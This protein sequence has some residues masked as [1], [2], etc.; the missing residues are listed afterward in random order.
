GTYLHAGHEFLAT[1][2]RRYPPGLDGCQVVPLAALL[3]P[4]P[5]TGL[6]VD[7]L[8]DHY[9]GGDLFALLDAYLTLLFDV[10]TTLFAYGVALE[11]H[12]QNTSLVLDTEHGRP[13]VRLLL[14]DH[15]GPRVH[16]ARLADALGAD[17]AA[18]LLGGFDDPRI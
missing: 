17:E 4:E 2:V 1:L 14:K 13:R 16:P 9:C 3:S 8:A 6:V 18:R 12:Q 15:D 7:T 10:H 5:G 11:S